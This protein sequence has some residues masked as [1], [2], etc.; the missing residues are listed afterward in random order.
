MLCC[1]LFQM[2]RCKGL[3]INCVDDHGNNALHLAAY[4]DRQQIAAFLMQ[5]GVKSDIHNENSKF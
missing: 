1:A 4:K 2:K 5:A 3:N